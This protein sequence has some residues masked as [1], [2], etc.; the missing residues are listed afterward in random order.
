MIELPEVLILARRIN[1]E[2]KGCRIA[3]G[4]R[5]NTFHKWVWY[6]REAEEYERLLAGKTVTGAEG[7]GGWLSVGLDPGCVL[8]CGDMGGRVLLHPGEA[9]LPKGNHLQIAFEDGRF[10]TIAVQ[11]W[12]YIA[13]FKE[14]EL[15]EHKAAG[16]IVLSPLSKE[17]T[18]Q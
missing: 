14:G 2:L 12:G 4:N 18:Y 8:A 16:S 17:F 15:P 1:K 10:V 11:G 7:K 9:E 3:S 6:N 13:L 5:G